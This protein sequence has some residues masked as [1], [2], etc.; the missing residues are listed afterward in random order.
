MLLP[1]SRAADAVVRV[2][3]TCLYSYGMLAVDV[4]RAGLKIT[5][6]VPMTP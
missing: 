2:R 1:K 6:L 4:L 5:G 3:T